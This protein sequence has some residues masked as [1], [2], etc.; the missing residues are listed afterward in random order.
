MAS[1]KGKPRNSSAGR[2][3]KISFCTIGYEKRTWTQFLRLLRREKIAVLADVRANPVSR[4]ADF[5]RKALEEHCRRAGI[6][7]Q[8]WQSLGATDAMRDQLHA[9]GDIARFLRR[10][11]AYAKRWLMDDIRRLGRELQSQN[12][13]LMC[14]EK[15]H[16]ECHRA[17]LAELLVEMTGAE[18]KPI[19]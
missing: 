5:R 12:T 19:L 16:E 8:S 4:K 7:Y 18:M 1:G 11:R 9:S 17:V 10:Y 6:E 15:V 14:Y 2:R 3:R 13:V